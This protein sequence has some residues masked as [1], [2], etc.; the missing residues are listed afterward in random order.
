MKT[1]K[2][3][4]T[5]TL[6]NGGIMN[7]Q[8]FR[9]GVFHLF[10]VLLAVAVSI[11]GCACPFKG[12]LA[13]DNEICI[14]NEWAHPGSDLTSDKEVRYGRLSNNM[15]YVVMENHEP[16]GRVAMHLYIRSGSL[17]EEEGAGW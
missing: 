12:L 10:L 4:S 6:V 15:G 1:S 7:K 14:S 3:F 9:R 11:S 8:I 16:R 5:L 17:N 13:P 2:P